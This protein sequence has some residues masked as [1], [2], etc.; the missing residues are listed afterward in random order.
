MTRVFTIEPDPAIAW[1][2]V[3]DAVMG[4]VSTG[5]ATREPDGAIVFSGTVSFER[6]GGFASARRPLAGAAYPGLGALRLRVVGDGKG[7]KLAAYTD[8]GASGFAYQAGF[9]TSAGDAS[10]VV[11][12]LASFEARFR[13]RPVGDAPPLE[14]RAI[15][16]IG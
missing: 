2:G 1:V 9:S 11:L 16:A 10:I 5:T 12:P 4:G 6:N 7:Y 13:G 3:N 15:R 14:A 8:A